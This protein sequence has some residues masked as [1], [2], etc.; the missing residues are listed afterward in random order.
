MNYESIDFEMDDWESGEDEVIYES[1]EFREQNSPIEQHPE[2]LISDELPVLP[3]RGVV[4]YPMMWLPLPI[5]QERSLRLVEDTLPSNRIIALVTSKDEE[6]DEPAPDEVYRIGTAAQVHRVLKTPDGTMRLLVQGLERIRLLEFTQEKPYLRAR[7]E[8]MPESI[9]EG[10]EMEALM[11]AVQELF[12]R[13]IELEPQMPDELTIMSINVDDARQLAYLVASSMRLKIEDAQAILEMDRVRDK[14]LR[15]IQLLKK[16]IEVLE[17][18]R[19]IQSEAQGEMERMQREFFLREQMRAIQKELGEEDEQTADIR[20]LEERIAAAG[21]SEEAEREALHELARMRRMPI[22]AAEYSV[23]KTYLDL[24]VSL[25]WR[26]ATV[27]NLDINHARKVLDEDHYGLT[28]IKERI[29]EFLAVRKLRA[30][31]RRNRKEEPEDLRDKI[32]REREGLVL[33]FVGP[34]GVGKTSL[35][36]SIARAMNRKF[37]RLALGG[38]RDEADIRGFRRTYIGAMPGRII[39]SLRRV[40]SRNPV[41]MLDEVDKLGRDFR[42]DPSSALLEVLDPEQNREF[43]DHYL[44]VAFDLSQVLFITTANVLDT[45]P[46]A[47]RDRMEIIQLSSYTE[48]EKVNIA[49]GYLVPRQIKEN[50]LRPSEVKFTDDALREIIQGYTREAGVRNLERQIGKVCRKIAAGV[51]A[52]EIKRGRTIKAKDVAT[53]LGKRRYFDEEIDERLENPGV[54]IGLVWTEAGGDIT[55]FEATR[56]PGAKGYVLTGQ[57][58]DV[59][60][61]SA[62]AALSYV[63]SRAESLGIDPDFFTHSDIHLHIPEGAIPKD[64]PS[65]GITMATAL[66]S[67]LTNRPVRPKLGMTGEITLRGKVLPVG[68]VKEKVLAAARYGL[69]TVILPRRNDSDLDELPEVVR[70]QMKFILVDTVD[71]VLAAALLSSEEARAVN[72]GQRAIAQIGDDSH[73]VRRRQPRDVRPSVVM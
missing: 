6:I 41:F 1:E 2:P 52:G 50:G 30:E 28:E 21:M 72:D 3:L 64:G 10:L 44:D 51:A 55:F 62:Q 14:L 9:E 35:G 65:A 22:Q 69:D 38:V 57:L 49:K 29:L 19:K 68:G 16:E 59:M 20:E 40:E 67:L 12:R 46:P 61:E 27:D 73:K 53:Y 24:L 4:V 11:R 54:A 71:E 66:A 32:R 56:M 15:L 17:L 63:R 18:G 8:I 58:G 36:L 45:I 31:R 25:P 37:V 23:I 60:K 26:N 7:I 5:G 13:L 70:K 42:G 39:Q 48:E 33:C 47:L 34:P 43:R